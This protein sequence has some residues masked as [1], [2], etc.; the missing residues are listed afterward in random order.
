VSAA[1]GAAELL[2]GWELGPPV[3]TIAAAGTLYVLGARRAGPWPQRRTAAFALGLAVL[4]VALQSA[5]HTWG[6]RLQSVHMAQHLLLCLVAAPLLAT[7]APV[8]LALRALRGGGRRLRR[9]L[10]SRPARAASHPA[11]GL[12]ALTASMLAVHLTGLYDLAARDALVHEAEHLALFAAGLLFWA[13]LVGADPAPCRP[14]A[15]GRIAWLLAAMLP[16]GLVS[17]VLLTGGPRSPA[18]ARSA[19]D[20]GV[21]PA[22]DQAHAAVV[23]WMGGALVLGIAVLVL[24]GAAL[25]REELRPRGRAAAR[26]W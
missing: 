17:A 15:A 12:A 23:M 18:Y 21:S 13:P 6:E 14:G 2:G 19:A 7:G 1:P 10:E 24:A 16:M 25:R 8:T 26:A 4:L 9:V 3:A 11:T 5:I 20:L 22:A